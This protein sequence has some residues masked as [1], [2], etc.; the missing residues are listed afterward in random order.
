MIGKALKALQESGGKHVDPNP[1]QAK[2]IMAG[3]WLGFWV[4]NDD[5]NPTQAKIIM[6]GRVLIILACFSLV[7]HAGHHATVLNR[8]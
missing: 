6:A 5:S 1:N 8:Q 3:S 2:I 4:R 7:L